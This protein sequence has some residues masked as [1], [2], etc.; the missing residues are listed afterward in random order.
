MRSKG[1]IVSYNTEKQAQIPLL[2]SLW[3]WEII[4]DQIKKLDKSSEFAE[5]GKNPRPRTGLP[6]F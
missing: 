4:D 3:D 1:Y 6:M 5:N 2:A